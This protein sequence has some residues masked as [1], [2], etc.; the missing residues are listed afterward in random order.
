MS[1]NNLSDLE[2]TLNTIMFYCIT[3]IPPVLTFIGFI[4]NTVTLLVCIHPTLINKSLYKWMAGLA[5]INNLMIITMWPHSYATQ[6]PFNSFTCPLMH[7]LT[8]T[9]YQTCCWGMVM[10][11]ID[12]LLQVAAPFKYEFTRK[13]SFV[14]ILFV[15]MLIVFS[16]LYVPAF[17]A[18]VPGSLIDC[19]WLTNDAANYIRYFTLIAAT[20]SPFI[21]MLICTAITVFVI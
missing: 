5:V 14:V 15:G 1:V 19:L 18:F 8:I 16:A 21:V 4:G 2:K 3:I 7:H 11:S 20:I 17:Y 6:I 12:R 13:T 9:L 10:I